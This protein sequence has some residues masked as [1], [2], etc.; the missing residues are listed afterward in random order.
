M[1]DHAGRP[2]RREDL[3]V[4]PR[5]GRTEQRTLASLAHPKAATDTAQCPPTAVPEPAAPAPSRRPERRGSGTASDRGGDSGSVPGPRP[6]RPRRRKSRRQRVRRALI[7]AVLVGAAV[8]GTTGWAVGSE[9]AAVTG[10]VPG[11]DDWRADHA[12]GRPLPD[13]VTA[14]PARIAAFFHGLDR[15]QRARLARRHPLVVG[16][17]D[18][19]PVGL[20][21]AANHRAL[22][23][24][25][26]RERRRARDRDSAPDARRQA[27][28]EAARYT[29]LLSP[30][31]HILAFDP[32]GRGQ[33]AEVYGDLRTARRTAVVVPGTDVDLGNFDEGG[34][35]TYGRPG[36]MATGL[37]AGMRAEAPGTRTAV[38]AWVGYTTPV[39]LGPDAATTRLAD[40]GAPR[41]QR[42]LRGLARTGAPAPAV[43]CHSYGSVV[44]GAAA[45]ELTRRDAR[46]LVAFG[47]PGMHA[48]SVAGLHTPARVWSARAPKDWIRRVPNVDVL[49][50]GHGRAPTDPGFGARV[51]TAARADG[52]TGY[53]A[54]GTDSRAN[55]SA[56]ALGDYGAVHCA[57]ASRECGGGGRRA[58]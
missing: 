5:T 21:Y 41:L 6:D 17:L 24:E 2:A 50:L 53:L 54:P 36:G 28:A 34:R 42:F 11:T 38:V 3:K 26:A 45:R 48:D 44:C 58:T 37:R 51:V 52:H 33:V 15:G 10:P 9:Q 57:A 8:A 32:R 40:A 56:I 55:F 31:R 30:G 12:L 1:K 18:G 35:N 49:G 39:G 23:T 43:L 13:P 20:R 16:N 29:R 14:G 4:A 19:A 7:A 27:R 46:D 47:S 25:A 22:R